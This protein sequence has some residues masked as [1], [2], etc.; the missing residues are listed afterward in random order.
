MRSPSSEVSPALPAPTKLAHE[1][2]V[3][4]ASAE[5]QLGVPGPLQPDAATCDFSDVAETTTLRCNLCTTDHPPCTSGFRAVWDHEELP[6]T[7][8]PSCTTSTNTRPLVRLALTEFPNLLTT[9][10]AAGAG[11]STA[12][13]DVRLENCEKIC[14]HETMQAEVDAVASITRDEGLEETLSVSQ[15]G[16]R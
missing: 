14:K 9:R 4:R 1:A 2:R 11:L 5:R 12:P 15:I 8:H 16:G 10:L 7:H 3:K 6:T 13:L